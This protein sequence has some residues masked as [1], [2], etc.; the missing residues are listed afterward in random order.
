MLPGMN[1]YQICAE[2]REAGDWTP[3]LMLTAKDGDLDQAEA[4]DTGADDYLM[5]PFS[6]PVLAGPHPRPAAPGRPGRSRLRSRSAT[7]AST[8]LSGGPGE[9]R[10]R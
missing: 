5:K 8:R 2:L 1:G 4:L 10:P 6:F 7:S 9:A 3:I